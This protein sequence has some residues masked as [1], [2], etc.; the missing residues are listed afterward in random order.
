MTGEVNET[1]PLSS[2]EITARVLSPGAVLRNRYRLEAELGRGGMGIVY[3]ATDL[4][5]KREVAVKVLSAAFADDSA[6][7]RLQR[8]ARAAA[9]LNHPHIVTVYDVGEDEG[10]PF[11][12]MELVHGPRLSESPPRDLE[13]AVNVAL[14]ICDALEHAHATGIVHRDLKPENVLFAVEDDSRSVKLADL[15]L[16]TPARDARITAAGSIVGTAAYMAPEQALG[17]A[18][19]GRA[20][21]YALGVLLYELCTGRLPFMGDNPLAIIS[22]HV[23]APPVPPRIL[24]A[25]IS[26]ALEATILRLL[27]KDPGRRYA[28]AAE[29][30]RA[31]M[32]ARADPTAGA[33][34]EAGG[35]I[36][37]LDALSRGRLV[38]RAEEFRQTRSLWRRAL[39]GQGCFLL[40]SGDPGVG[41]T[42][43]AREILIQAALDGAVM[44]T[45]ACYEYEATTP[46]L[47]FVEAFRD[48]TR[49][50]EDDAALREAL[51]DTAPE[52]AKLVPELSA[53]LGPFP[54][55]A[56]LS[57]HEERLY[58]FDAMARVLR[59]L[60]AGRGLIYYIDDLHWADSSTLW[61]LGHLVRSLRDE[62][63]LFVSSYREIELDRA[64]P[65]SKA[66]VEWN[67]ERLTTRLVLRPFGLEETRAQMAALLGES[68]STE[69]AAAVY[70]ET[71]GNPFFVEEVVKALIEEGAFHREQGHWERWEIPDLVI[72]QS[73]KAAIGNRLDRVSEECNGVLRAAAVLG[74]NFEFAELSLTAGSPGE[75]ALLD[76]LDEA[77]AA[78]LLTA[79][80]DER[81]A[82][83]H[84]K[85][86]EVLYEELN[87][88]RRRR[89]HK[90]AAEGLQ[91]SEAVAVE[92]LA[93]HFIEAGDHE[94]GLRY[95]K[96]AAREAERVFAYTEALDAYGR[97]V[98]CAEA[99]EL[100]GEQAALEEAM[101][102]ACFGG[103]E[104]IAA[105]THYERALGLVDHPEARTRL[106]CRAGSA[107][108]PTGDPVGLD[109]VR[110]ALATLDAET[111]PADTALALAIEAR[112]HHLAGQHRRAIDMLERAAEL[113]EPEVDAAPGV[114]DVHSMLTE[115]YAYLSGAHQHLGRYEDA[116]RWARKLLAFGEEYDALMAQAI[117]YEFLGENC[118]GTGEW[119][120]G[121]EHAAKEREI[122]E[123]MRSRE[124]LSWACFVESMCAAG[125]GDLDRGERATEEAIRLS[126]AIGEKRLHALLTGRRP[127]FLVQRGRNEDA[128]AASASAIEEADA[129]GLYFMRSEARRIAADVHF[130]RGD[131]DRAL[132]FVG[133]VLALSEGKESRSGRLLIGPLHVETLLA[134][135]RAAEAREQVEIFADLVAECQSPLY[136][137][138]VARLRALAAEA[139]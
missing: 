58:F 9:A 117:A 123:R 119:E 13:E 15:G 127:W 47:P 99:L 122:A 46:Y 116:N 11:F 115:V 64:H 39:D 94:Q 53:R 23:H 43:L 24:R 73:V 1:R 36:A 54:G 130:R 28:S 27:E 63:V 113:L 2:G 137:R 128:L 87:P 81:F 89:L 86:R 44:L 67:R 138:E 129:L 103:G 90:R 77:V 60:A 21:L 136:D 41:K 50:R 7:L 79:D 38:G 132:E 80:R 133:E 71:E 49:T 3:R 93:H 37:L 59:A 91:A 97:A 108:V 20:D 4:E 56:K 98:E 30:A 68:I 84:D 124:R 120:R 88:I 10:L 69:L 118:T 74:K 14:Q 78:Q 17:Q 26:P 72:P 57:P 104:M 51:G 85:I 109:Y 48:W 135:G 35:T 114:T 34:A 131:Y 134:A 65:L 16:A 29:T 102:D 40:L 95:A 112:F 31:L 125:H 22:Q 111:H 5:L 101:G 106:L 18:L 25:E 32:T 75:D 42:R 6:R 110:E 66:L 61:L 96:E 83:T 100:R 52:I 12:I 8:E 62:P 105:R 45:G 107:C 92:I 76:V 126:E 33:D 82:F 19:D 70:R 121:L 139:E 55:R